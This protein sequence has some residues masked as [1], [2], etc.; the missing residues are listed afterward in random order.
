MLGKKVGLICL[1]GV[2]LCG[3]GIALAAAVKVELA[4]YPAASPIEPQ[5]SGRMVLNYAKGADK[6]VVQL[7][8][9]GLMPESE[10]TVYLSPDSGI[11][12]ENIG[13][14][15]TRKN[16]TGNLHVAL[17][18]DRS[19]DLPAVNNAANETVLLGS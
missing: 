4:P 5:A 15:T 13:T 18:G 11:T 12:W 1:V 16:G 9:W 17:P 7:N 10:Y 8:C 3:T 6:T 14:F 19:G 2:I